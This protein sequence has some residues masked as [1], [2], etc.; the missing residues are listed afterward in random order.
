MKH[1]MLVAVVVA[2]AIG[3]AAC[4]SSGK[5]AGGNSTSTTS[6]KP[7][8]DTVVLMTYDS[9]A[10]SKDV[11]ALFT[12]QTGFKVKVLKA[13]DAGRLLST[14]IQVKDHPVADALFGVD[15]T[16]L[17]RALDEKLFDPYRAKHLAS[18]PKKYQLDSEHR[19]TPIDAG[20]VC[21]NDDLAWFGHDG[22]PP[23]PTSL[24]DLAKPEY[25]KLLVVENPATSS[26]GLAFLLSTISA[27]GDGWQDYWK[28]LRSNGVRV[29]DGWD[30][31]YQTDFTAGSASG[32]RPLVV[33]YAT[34]PAADVVFSDGKKTTPTVGVVKGTCFSQVEFAG[35]LR[36]AKNPQGAQALVDFMLSTKY[37]EGIPLQMY[38]YPAVSGTKLPGVFTKFATQ[39]PAH[40]MDVSAI[41]DHRNEWIN[42]WTQIVLQ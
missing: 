14:A 22:H 30:E 10:A 13:G 25:K 40:S 28:S 38:V 27:Y 19:V 1:R 4:G 11:L 31:A 35:V 23:A 33:S 34:D 39:P 41:G 37:Q 6:G 29:V 21:V 17:T 20:E 24:A 3:G 16:F 15:N 9:Y 32:D 26:P 5:S 42:Q 12:R 2:L 36:G 8:S 7:A 18:V